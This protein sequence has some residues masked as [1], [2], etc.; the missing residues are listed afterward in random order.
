MTKA[1]AVYAGLATLALLYEWT[2]RIP[3][4]PIGHTRRFIDDAFDRGLPYV[5][6]KIRSP[7]YLD[8]V[9]CEVWSGGPG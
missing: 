9:A 3:Y 7:R 8:G 1:L 5:V 2:H 4:L 6:I